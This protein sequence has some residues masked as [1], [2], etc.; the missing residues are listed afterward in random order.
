[1]GGGREGGGLVV[2]RTSTVGGCAAASTRASTCA[3]LNV[4]IVGSGQSGES[5]RVGGKRQ[6]EEAG[7][8]PNGPA[9]G[10][11]SPFPLSLSPPCRAGVWFLGFPHDDFVFFLPQTS[12]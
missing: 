7:R 10:S 1:M 6:E 4:C 9:L 8:G 11:S 5:Q 12:G 2:F 3:V